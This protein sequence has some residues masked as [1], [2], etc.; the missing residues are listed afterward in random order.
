MLYRKEGFPDE[1]ELVLC[2]VTA[3]HGNGVFAK[4]DEYDKTGMIHI[5]EVSPGRIRNIRDFVVEGKKIVCKVLKID[6]KKGHIDLSLRR[7]N[8][9]QKR[10]KNNEIKQEQKAEKIVEGVAKKLNMDVKELYNKI[11]GRIFEK[12]EYMHECFNDLVVGKTSLEKIGVEEG[13]AR[14]MT[15]AVKEKIRPPE[16][17]VKGVLKLTSYDPDGIE[18]VKGALKKAVGENISVKYKGAG[19][20]NVIVNAPNYKE[21][22]KIL[23]N[24][25]DKATRYMEKKKGII[26]FAKTEK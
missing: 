25:V 26:S 17:Q 21:A 19:E 5:S 9:G 4:L 13:F 24:S 7:V 2:T 23:K 20:Y 14:E 6:R 15:E 18:I 22:E 11:G 16:V 3:V 8:E 10:K 12:Y 1:D